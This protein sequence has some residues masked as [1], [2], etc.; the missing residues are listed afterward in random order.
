MRA[1]CDHLRELGP[2]RHREP[3]N[4]VTK[5]AHLNHR[6]IQLGVGLEPPLT[7]LIAHN[8]HLL[9]EPPEHLSSGL[10]LGL[11]LSRE[12]HLTTDLC[13]CLVQSAQA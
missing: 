4:E 5:P 8:P 10:L 13:P 9:G 6:L 3:D 7:L 11:V 2:E 12:C 1:R